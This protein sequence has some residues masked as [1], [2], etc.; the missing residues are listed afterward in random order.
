VVRTEH[1][2]YRPRK[3]VVRRHYEAERG[4]GA[5]APAPHG[6]GARQGKGAPQK[7]EGGHGSGKEKSD[8]K[9]D[10]HGKGAH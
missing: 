2:P 6:G 7:N 1:Y 5:S 9:Q 3:A 8:K 4:Q 10:E